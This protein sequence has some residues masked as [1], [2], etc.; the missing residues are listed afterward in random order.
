MASSHSHR[1][2]ARNRRAG[3]LFG[4]SDD[5]GSS[6]VNS[7]TVKTFDH[8][9]ASFAVEA[10]GCSLVSKVRS[11]SLTDGN[12]ARHPLR[13]MSLATSFGRLALCCVCAIGVVDITTRR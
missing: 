13:G 3:G 12:H 7:S 9:Y 1:L 10:L 8:E 2:F 6:T 5:S 4:S 11:L